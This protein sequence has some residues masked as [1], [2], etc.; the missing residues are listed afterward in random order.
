M[1]EFHFPIIIALCARIC[2]PC[3]H[4]SKRQKKEKRIHG[5]IP[6]ITAAQCRMTN[7]KPNVSRDAQNATASSFNLRNR[8]LRRERE[9]TLKD[10]EKRRKQRKKREK[11]KRQKHETA[12]HGNVTT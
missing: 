6:F 11:K 7:A 2:K 1:I 5:C 12:K 4:V 8:S 10:R 9:E 3:T